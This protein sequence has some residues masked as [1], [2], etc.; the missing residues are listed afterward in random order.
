MVE[1]NRQRSLHPRGSPNGTPV[2]PKH[3]DGVTAIVWIVLISFVVFVISQCSGKS[4]N[5]PAA[6][7][8]IAQQA[9]TSAIQAQSAQTVEP[10]GRSN[11]RI[12]IAHLK[13]AARAEELAGEMIYSQNCYD[14]LGRHFTWAKLDQCGAFDMGAS[15]SLGD[16]SALSTD[17]EALWFQSEVAAGRYLKAAIAAGEEA[18]KADIRLNDLQVAVKASHPSGFKGNQPSASDAASAE[19]IG[20]GI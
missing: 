15:Q 18:G 14:A 13:L 12:G 7:N 20:N 3:N 1:P 17:K 10:L 5:T 11:V 8:E 16:D 6:Q 19:T 2:P 9:I 4:S